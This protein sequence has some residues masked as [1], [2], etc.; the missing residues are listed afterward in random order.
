MY[1]GEVCPLGWGNYD[2]FY[3]YQPGC[4]R[5]TYYSNPTPAS[6]TD[7]YTGSQARPELFIEIGD[8][9]HTPPHQLRN[10]SPEVKRQEIPI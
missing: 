7:I 6:N 4:N 5:G 2:M 3:S 8:R 10:G 9:F 1:G